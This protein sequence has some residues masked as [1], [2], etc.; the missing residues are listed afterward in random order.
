MY[1]GKYQNTYHDTI[2]HNVPH[3]YCYTSLGMIDNNHQSRPKHNLDDKNSNMTQHINLVH[4]RIHNHSHNLVFLYSKYWQSQD[5][6]SM[7]QLR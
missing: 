6:S 5:C 4:T 2:H 7:L 3:K 1:C